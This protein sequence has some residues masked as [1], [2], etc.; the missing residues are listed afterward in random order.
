MTRSLRLYFG[1][2]CID[3]SLRLFATHIEQFSFSVEGLEH[4]GF[5]STSSDARYAL[6][7]CHIDVVAYVSRFLERE[8][9]SSLAHLRLDLNGMAFRG[10]VY[11]LN[12]SLGD[13]DIV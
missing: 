8:H 13:V 4:E 6:S 3:C 2:R 1:V 7:T 12:T 9:I 10:W 5:L 11:H